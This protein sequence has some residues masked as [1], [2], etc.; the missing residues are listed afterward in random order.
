[1]TNY[2]EIYHEFEQQARGPKLS[3]KIIS[4]VSQKSVR[5]FEIYFQTKLFLTTPDVEKF[6]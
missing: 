3:T 5:L 2:E 4:I 6:I 1:M